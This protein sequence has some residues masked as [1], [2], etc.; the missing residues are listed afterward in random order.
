MLI[1]RFKKEGREE[2]IKEERKEGIKERRKAV[3]KTKLSIIKNLLLNTDF[4]VA[5]IAALTDVTE[6]FVRK[7]KKSLK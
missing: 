7:V 3:Q 1:E 4:T 5:K 2:G 6:D